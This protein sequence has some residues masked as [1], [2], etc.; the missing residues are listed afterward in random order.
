MANKYNKGLSKLN[1]HIKLQPLK[2]NEV[3]CF[4]LYVIMLNTKLIRDKLKH[5][6]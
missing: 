5:F 4:H 3:H 1:K 6:Y 2:K